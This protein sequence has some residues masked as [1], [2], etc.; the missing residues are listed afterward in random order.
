MHASTDSLQLW[1][2]LSLSASLEIP[3][4]HQA[5]ESATDL[6]IYINHG[7]SSAKT[8]PK[9]WLLDNIDIKAPET[10][11]CAEFERLELQLSFQRIQ[12]ASRTM[13]KRVKSC[14]PDPDPPD[15]MLLDY[16]PG[17]EEEAQPTCV[18]NVVAVL[19]DE[20]SNSITKCF[21]EFKIN[22]PGNTP[23]LLD[24]MLRPWN[25]KASNSKDDVTPTA[26]SAPVEVP[27]KRRRGQSFLKETQ[28]KLLAWLD[29][30]P[31]NMSPTNAEKLELMKQT[32]L[33]R[34][35]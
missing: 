21:G 19:R 23:K 14:P 3:Q 30:H 18:E 7:T 12:K 10:V 26:D 27:G 35:M 15:L 1:S 16:I 2:Q 6:S 13:S 5:T 31:G 11:L 33:Q 34:G 4:S 20:L 8:L 32:G 24:K 29:A 17:L 28:E 9:A 22:N 25:D